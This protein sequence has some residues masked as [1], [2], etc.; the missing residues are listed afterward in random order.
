[1]FL[2]SHR[3]ANVRSAGGDQFNSLFDDVFADF[4]VPVWRRGTD[5]RATNVAAQARFDVVEK[6]DHYEA[7]VD[8]PG[9]S[10]D[11]IEVNI[12]GTRVSLKAEAKADET[13]KDGERV[14]YAER[15]ATRWAR[16]FELPEE[17][18]DERAEASFENGVLKLSLPK[19]HLAQPKRLTIR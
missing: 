3:P 5:G 11:D 13:L 8:L 1:M 12:E 14:L 2:S 15:H 16:T 4:L 7:Y 6:A 9:V 19:K 17:I 10:K 18:D